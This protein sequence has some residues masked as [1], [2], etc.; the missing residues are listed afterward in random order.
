MDE[1]FA[2]QLQ[3]FPLLIRQASVRKRTCRGMTKDKTPPT[4]PS[5]KNSVGLQNLKSLGGSRG[6]SLR[7]F[8]PDTHVRT[9][10]IVRR[11]LSFC[12]F[13]PRLDKGGRSKHS[14]IAWV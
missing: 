7:F 13:L 1:L 3:A 9:N 14:S 2:H 12:F 10:E 4:N 6:M 11:K 5:S 8:S